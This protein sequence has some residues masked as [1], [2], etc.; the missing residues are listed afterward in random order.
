M[1]N[2]DTFPNYISRIVKAFGKD[3]LYFYFVPFDKNNQ[4]LMQYH[5]TFS[6]DNISK[7]NPWTSLMY[8]KLI[9]GSVC[10]ISL[11]LRRFLSGEK[12]E[13]QIETADKKKVKIPK[14]EMYHFLFTIKG[15]ALFDE[16]ETYTMQNTDHATQKPIEPEIGIIHMSSKKLFFEIFNKEFDVDNILDKINSIGIENLRADEREYLKLHSKSSQK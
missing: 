2:S 15:V 3:R 8:A 14:K 11:I 5:S 13:V 12:N 4:V 10:G 7:I 1:D 9:S 16:K 6:T